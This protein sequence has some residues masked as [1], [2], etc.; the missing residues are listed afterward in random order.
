M[1]RFWAKV[2]KDGPV[3][4]YV[5]SPCWDCLCGCHDEHNDRADHD[6]GRCG[7]DCAVCEETS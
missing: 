5:G 1:K 2:R 7:D 3:V 6:L 4:P